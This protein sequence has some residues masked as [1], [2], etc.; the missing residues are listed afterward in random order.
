MSD[1][2]VDAVKAE[3]ARL[4]RESD[5]YQL[6]GSDFDQM[7]RIAAHAM[8]RMRRAEDRAD[9][10]EQCIGSLE[11]GADHI[12]ACLIRA[13]QHIHMGH[14]GGNYRTCEQDTCRHFREPLESV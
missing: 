9:A 13:I 12:R 5:Q 1:L 11:E 14:G 2:S 3:I 10:A 7:R 8:E 4:R 6:L